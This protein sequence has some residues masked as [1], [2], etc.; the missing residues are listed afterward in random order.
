MEVFFIVPSWLRR[1]GRRREPPRVS[2]GWLDTGF[3]QAFSVFDRHVLA[4]PVAEVHQP[5]AMDRPRS[6]GQFSNRS[7]AALAECICGALA[8][9]A[10]NRQSAWKMLPL[11]NIVGHQ[12]ESEY[13][14]RGV[15]VQQIGAEWS[16]S[17]RAEG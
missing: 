7:R 2:H 13:P 3:C 14:K 15:K 4:S 17:R 9:P 16:T 11:R 6:C 5:G 1:L 10:G 8:R 12:M